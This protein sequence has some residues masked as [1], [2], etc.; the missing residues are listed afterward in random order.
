[1]GKMSEIKELL[2][3]GKTVKEIKELGYKSPSIYKV[4]KQIKEEPE[5]IEQAE[6][7]HEEEHKEDSEIPET[8]LDSDNTE[9][10]HSTSD[11][12]DNNGIP[13]EDEEEEI[14]EEIFESDDSYFREY[15]G[16]GISRRGVDI[17][18]TINIPG[19]NTKTGQEQKGSKGQLGLP[20]LLAEVYGTI[21]IITGHEHWSLQPKDQKVIKHLCKLPGIEKFLHKFGLYGCILSLF[22]ITVSRLKQEIKLSKEPK[23]EQNVK[24]NVNIVTRPGTPTNIMEGITYESETIPNTNDS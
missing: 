10:H 3:V 24:Q 15:D 12:I 7:F 4:K 14:T 19:I 5:V 8:I 17:N 22:T 23:Q 11:N 1:M 9:S 20:E 21:A 2:E 18:S 6:P 13:K 16:V